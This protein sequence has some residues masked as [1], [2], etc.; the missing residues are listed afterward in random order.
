MLPA[1]SIIRIFVLSPLLIHWSLCRKLHSLTDNHGVLALTRLRHT[2]TQSNQR[3]P[4]NNCPE[5]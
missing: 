4:I 5:K 2:H 3:K 1:T